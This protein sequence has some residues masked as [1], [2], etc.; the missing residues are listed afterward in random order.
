MLRD[1]FLNQRKAPVV[2][3]SGGEGGWMER[4]IRDRN[5]RKTV[6]IGCYEERSGKFQGS[7]IIM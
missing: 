5:N 2:L 4:Q 3:E 1:C 7:L 6:V